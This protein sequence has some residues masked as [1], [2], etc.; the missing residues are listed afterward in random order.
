MANLAAHNHQMAASL[1]DFAIQRW[2]ADKGDG[3][4][5]DIAASVWTELVARDPVAADIEKFIRNVDRKA[6]K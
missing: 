2:L 5:R 6:A 1:S 4:Q 3:G